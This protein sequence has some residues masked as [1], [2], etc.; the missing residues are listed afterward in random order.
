MLRA[1]ATVHKGK[2]KGW[3]L[4]AVAGVDHTFTGKNE[5]FLVTLV[6]RQHLTQTL[7]RRHHDAYLG[8]VYNFGF[9]V[10]KK[11]GPAQS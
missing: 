4:H 10:E 2:D 11:F 3:V 9:P 6:M 8:E 1:A 5:R 7:V